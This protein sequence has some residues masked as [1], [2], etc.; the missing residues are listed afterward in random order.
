MPEIFCP[1]IFGYLQRTERRW[2]VATIGESQLTNVSRAKSS[3]GVIARFSKEEMFSIES[4]PLLIVRQIVPLSS[5]AR[6][7]LLL[8]AQRSRVSYVA[9]GPPMGFHVV[10]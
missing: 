10:P 3:V 4:P 5:A 2:I 7:M 1:I 8:I 9:L 6:P